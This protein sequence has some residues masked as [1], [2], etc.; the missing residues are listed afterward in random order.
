MRTTKTSCP[1][2]LTYSIIK[3]N[4]Q[5]TCVFFFLQVHFQTNLLVIWSKMTATPGYFNAILLTTYKIQVSSFC[6]HDQMDILIVSACL[7][8]LSPF[9]Q[10]LKFSLYL[11]CLFFFCPSLTQQQ[12]A[13][14]YLKKHTRCMWYPTPAYLRTDTHTHTYLSSGEDTR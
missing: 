4:C 11:S 2:Y 14:L 10:A 5:A 3:V 12:A 8:T 6:A 13:V 9:S 7:S 1:S